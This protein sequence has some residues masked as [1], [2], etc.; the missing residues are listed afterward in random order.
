MRLRL[1]SRSGCPML[2]SQLSRPTL[3]PGRHSSLAILPQA[4]PE[5]ISSLT[6]RV[7]SKY[8]TIT[9]PKLLACLRKMLLSLETHD[10]SF[11]KS[12]ANDQQTSFYTIGMLLI[13]K[14]TSERI[15]EPSAR[16]S[17]KSPLWQALWSLD[18]VSR[19]RDPSHRR[20]M[21]KSM[22][23]GFP[24]TRVRSCCYAENAAV[25]I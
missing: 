3:P 9:K 6:A 10:A 5:R 17:P 20:I 23:K 14:R 2:A 7:C 19:S 12:L 18:T 11:R 1:D 15:S 24:S 21:S 25:T 4:T 13:Y 8:G 16:A 22:S